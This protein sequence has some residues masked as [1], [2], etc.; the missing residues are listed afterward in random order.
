MNQAEK[1]LLSDVKR[2]KDKRKFIKIG[3]QI[4]ESFFEIV[5]DV[6]GQQVTDVSRAMLGYYLDL[7]QKDVEVGME[8][9]KVII[10]GYN[11]Y[12]HTDLFA[13]Y[14]DS[15]RSRLAWLDATK[16]LNKKDHT[17]Q[18][19]IFNTYFRWYVATYELFRKMLIFACYC[20][21]E[22]NDNL[23]LNLENYLFGT[24]DPAKMLLNSGNPS[25]KKLI[26]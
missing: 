10:S 26:D 1:K 25:R 2:L 24:A 12:P 15:T 8:A 21:S 5:K 4:G 17:V 3:S 20:I 13:P 18:I 19:L 14:Y 22:N 23:N 6:N 9:T 11:G 16:R 7:F